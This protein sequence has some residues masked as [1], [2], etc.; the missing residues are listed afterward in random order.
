MNRSTSG[1]ASQW[2][3]RIL[4]LA[5]I[6][7][8]I[9]GLTL[10]FGASGPAGCAVPSTQANQSA[11]SD[12]LAVLTPHFDAVAQA[13]PDQAAQVKDLEANWPARSERQNY[14][15]AVP[16]LKLRERDVPALADALQAKLWSWDQRLQK[17]GQ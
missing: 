13:H 5:C 12:T 15:L 10:T 2:I 11:A 1:A 16:I 9:L 7:L 4:D 8:V 17:F 6:A 3:G 14:A